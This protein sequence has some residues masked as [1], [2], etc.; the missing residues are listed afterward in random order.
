MNLRLRG[1]F[2]LVTGGSHGI[3]RS[4][5]LTLASEGCSMAICARDKSRIDEVTREIRSKGVNAMGICADATVLS[6]IEHVM[7]NINAIW[8]RLH[9]LVNNVGG[10]GIWNTTDI[11]KN[12][13]SLWAEV[14]NRN[15]TSSLRF[16]M[17]AL[18]FMRKEKWGRVVTISSIYGHEAGGLHPW[19]NVA[20]TAQVSLMKN[21]SIDQS[22][23][24]NG[25]TFNTVAPGFIMVPHT[26]MHRRS[27]EQLN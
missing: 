2:A 27:T 7:E 18:L 9:I 6:D 3:G 25:I 1:K 4:I 17:L 12:H 11:E 16:T 8:G 26:G 23:A 13:E 22:L 21:L 5:A 10:G 24:A 19:Y 15:V 20:K 14:Y